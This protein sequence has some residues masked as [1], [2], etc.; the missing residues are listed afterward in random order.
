MKKTVVFIVLLL[1]VA[2][3][4]ARVYNGLVN[5]D[6][7]VSNAWAKVESDYQR[8]ADLIPNLVETVK[9]YAAHEKETY[10]AVVEA[11][12]NATKIQLN[13]D[14]LTEENLQKF[15]AAQS[16]LNSALSR[17]IAVSE[18]YPELKA[19]ENFLELQAQLEGTENR[20]KESRNA[21]NDAV[22]EYNVKVRKFPNN[23]IAGI[24]GFDKKAGFKAAEGSDKAPTV[25]FN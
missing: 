12:A 22:K 11:R 23:I 16:E 5:S 4:G 2:F 15:Q 6:E 20:I 19:N 21:F 17:L 14:E 9:G 24:M 18:N 3:W 1:I 8:R 7:S 13:V 25:D 10:Q